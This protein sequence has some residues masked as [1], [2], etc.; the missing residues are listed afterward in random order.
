MPGP[1]GDFLM[2]Y[3]K[4][5]EAG[6]YMVSRSEDGFNWEEPGTILYAEDDTHNVTVAQSPDGTWWLYY[7]VVNQECMVALEN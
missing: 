4:N 1:D 2:H 5:G 7:N 3:M 6:T